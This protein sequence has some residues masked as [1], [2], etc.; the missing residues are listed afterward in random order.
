MS[1]QATTTISLRAFAASQVLPSWVTLA[2]TIEHASI[3]GWSLCSHSDPTADGREGLTLDEAV[4][5]GT[6]DP[7]LLYLTRS[8]R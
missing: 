3:L 5:I 7:S 1:E 4:E 8:S 2:D 6:E